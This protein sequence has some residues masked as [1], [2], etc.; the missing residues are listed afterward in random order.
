MR[1]LPNAI[2]AAV[3]VQA[4]VVMALLAV[5]V[6]GLTALFTESLVLALQPLAPL[7]TDYG[8]VLAALTAKGAT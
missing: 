3:S 4:I 7:F 6:A 5:P 1:L 8:A 2:A